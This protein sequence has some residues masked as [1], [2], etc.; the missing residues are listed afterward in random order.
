MS[1]RV[2]ILLATYEG[3]RYLP[4]QLASIAAQT[5][6]DWVLYWRDDGSCDGSVALLDAFAAGAG[7]GRVVRVAGGERLGAAGSFFHLLR[8]AVVAESGAAAFA[9]ADQD[10]VWRP[11]KLAV[12]LAALER[13]D[14]AFA[15]PSRSSSLLDRV[16]QTYG[17]ATYG[18]HALADRPGPTLWFCRT[19]LVDAALRPIGIQ[20][21]LGAPYGFPAAL[22]ENTA[23]GCAMLLD[24]AAARLVAAS[25]PPAGCLHDWWAHIL[26]GAAG[27]MVLR[28]DAPLVLYRLHGGNLVGSRPPP[29]IQR[30]VA[31]LIRGPRFQMTMLR[32]HLD[33]L[34]AH[35]ALLTPEA[36]ASVTRLRA[37]L[38]GGLLRRA[39]ALGLAGLR[40]R[41][42]LR[43]WLFRLWFLLG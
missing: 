33:G 43:T 24:A 30:A 14:I 22:V 27:G 16:I 25:A 17:D 19:A 2:A 13:Y 8:H 3:E 38:A 35:P 1:R 4:E 11:E 31:A 37:A 18:H 29:L 9:F 32:C 21:N 28:E 6:A 15:P 26:V 41:R 42:R 12:G 10:D 36:L 34:A 39:S 5:H 20:P 7:A 40:G 23:G